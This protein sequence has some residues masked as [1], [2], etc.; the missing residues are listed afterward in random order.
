[1]R[2]KGSH[3]I[4][5]SHDMLV[6]RLQHVSSR[7]FWFLLASLCLWVKLQNLSCFMVSKQVVMWFCMPGVALRDILRCLQTCRKSFC[8]ARAILLRRLQKRRCIFRGRRSTLETSIVILCGRGSIIQICACIY[9]YMYMYI[10]IYVY[11]YICIYIYMYMYI[12]IYL[13]CSPNAE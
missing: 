4:E 1:M 3:F 8:V 9:I 5:V 10:Y 13:P 7:F 6:L 11:I 12:Y 2:S